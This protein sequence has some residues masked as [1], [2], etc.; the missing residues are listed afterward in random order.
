MKR[1]SSGCDCPA[2]SLVVELGGAPVE[3]GGVGRIYGTRRGDLIGNCVIA[4]CARC[5]FAICLSCARGYM[6]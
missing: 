2:D 6:F 5:I 4:F 3:E 1:E